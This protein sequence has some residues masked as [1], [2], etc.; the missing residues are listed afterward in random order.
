LNLRER[1]IL[2]PAA[3]LMVLMGVFSPFFL[4]KMDVSAAAL[5]RHVR[6]R[7]VRVQNLPQPTS[8]PLQHPVQGSES[9]AGSV[10][11]RRAPY[12]AP[13]DSGAEG[14]RKAASLHAVAER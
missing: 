1:T 11:K 13:S 12:Q 3:I 9:P 2:I 4:R 7:E 8:L 5:L 6:R 10:V 14:R